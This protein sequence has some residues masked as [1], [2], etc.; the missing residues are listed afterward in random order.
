VPVVAI[1]PVP[2]V[3]IEPVP[4]VVSKKK[5]VK[6]K[7]L[8]KKVEIQ[9]PVSLVPVMVEKDTKKDTK[10]ATK[11]VAKKAV[12]EV[13][14]EN[15]VVVTSELVS[16]EAVLV[17]VYSPDG[18]SNPVGCPGAPIGR[19]IEL[20]DDENYEDFVVREKKINGVMYYIDDENLLF[21]YET[22]EHIGNYK[23]DT[24]SIIFL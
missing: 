1:E 16:E 21:D 12:K 15:E 2:V 9:E 23:E 11:K 24:D 14:V 8:T 17:K 5:P 19:A 10:I 20:N 6:D 4:V 13:E 22:D 7:K 3:A 18:S